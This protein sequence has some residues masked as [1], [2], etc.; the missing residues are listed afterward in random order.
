MIL[1]LI[2]FFYFQL[3][4]V[5]SQIIFEF[6]KKYSTFN[7]E[8]FSN[9]I[10][11]N[12]YI[13]KLIIGNPK[14]EIPLSLEFG[15]FYFYISHKN[16]SGIFDEKKSITF[17]NLS[18]KYK[19]ANIKES[20]VCVDNVYFNNYNNNTL[21][22]KDL[23]FLL[24]TNFNNQNLKR[25]S[26]I[27]LTQIILYE[28]NEYNFIYQLQKNKKINHYSFYYNYI[29]DSKGKLFI[30]ALPHEIDKKNF[31]ENNYLKYKLNLTDKTFLWQIY[32]D[33]INY[34]DKNFTNQRVILNTEFQGIIPNN[35]LKNLLKKYFFDEY[36]NNGLCL[37]LNSSYHSSYSYFV[38]DTRINIKK[39]KPFM[40]YNKELNY[41]FNLT[42]Q[43]VFIKKNNLYYC[44]IL[45]EKRNERSSWYIGE[46]FLKKY[47]LVFEQEKGTIGF[48]QNNKNNSFY[49]NYDLSLPWVLFFFLFFSMVF[50]GYLLKK[51]TMKNKRR[52]RL[53]EIEENFEYISKT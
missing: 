17:K 29:S 14:Q 2:S 32:F 42:Y 9:Y 44:L 19:F 16:T 48:Y 26:Q 21:T 50:L 25:I 31:L 10:S 47:L 13:S 22:N 41:T 11:E 7:Q 8:N 4:N 34:L 45:Y 35:E 15:E 18:K 12:K 1:Y 27:G 49:F 52:I 20:F 39:F 24:V 3:I 37:L 23:K 5:Y 53:N 46:I 40:F 43:D 30:G 38:C 33:S 36:L 51:I 28:F 6:E